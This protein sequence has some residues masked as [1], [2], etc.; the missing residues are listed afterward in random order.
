MMKA[1]ASTDTHVY[2]RAVATMCLGWG[3]IAT[4][5]QHRLGNNFTAFR[6]VAE[7]AA[8]RVA[9]TLWLS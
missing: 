4:S 8:R 9:F 2:C 7:R 1:E 5:G 6:R 3:T